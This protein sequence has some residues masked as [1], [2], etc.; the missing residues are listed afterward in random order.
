MSQQFYEVLDDV[1]RPGRWFIREPVSTG[2]QIRGTQFFHTEPIVRGEPFT[3]RLRRR[4]EPSDFT[5]ADFGVPILRTS[6][7]EAMHARAPGDMQL[8]PVRLIGSDTPF[9]MMNVLGVADC[10]NTSASKI[11]YWPPGFGLENEGKPLSV[12]DPVIDPSRTGGHNIFRIASWRAPII[13]TEPI[14]ELL[15]SATGV[16]LCALESVEP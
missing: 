15:R 8:I 6:L 16:K 11:T 7:A 10:L 1:T 2:T 3:M 5:F 14:A 13:V 9:V 12:I 4:G